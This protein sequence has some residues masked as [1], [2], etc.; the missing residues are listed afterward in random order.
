MTEIAVTREGRGPELLLVHGGASPATTWEALAPLAAH[1][2]LVAVHRR[3]YPPSPPGRHDFDQDAADLS[4]LLESRPHLIAHSYGGLGAL[5]A[6]S[7]NPAGVR[8][9]TMI[10]PPLFRVVDDDPDVDEL[11]RLGNDC[12]IN[13]LDAEPAGLR[14]FLRLAG[15][16]GISDEGPLPEHVVRGVRRAHG[17]RLPGEARPDLAKLRDARIPSLVASGGHSPG[18]ERICDALAKELGGERL[19]FE[20]AGH[21]VQRSPVFR[22]RLEQ[23]LR[24]AR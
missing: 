23:H 8:S 11:E 13:G 20:G 3:G 4:P 24:E 2:T 6:A 14:Q 15:A 17:G 18:Q 12:L 16:E 7:D 21:F 10:E 5:L 19:L 22:E 1:W 9:L